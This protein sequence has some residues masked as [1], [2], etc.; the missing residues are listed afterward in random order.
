MEVMVQS[1]RETFQLELHT[2]EGYALSI[3]GM[4]PIGYSSKTVNA[5]KALEHL[6]LNTKDI[7]LIDFILSKAISDAAPPWTQVVGAS[8]KVP[9]VSESTGGIIG[10]PFSQATSSDDGM[11]AL[12][13]N[14]WLIAYAG[15]PGIAFESGRETADHVASELNRYKMTLSLNKERLYQILEPVDHFI[16]VFDGTGLGNEAIIITK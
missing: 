4:V 9:G 12:D 3:G 14:L 2:C 16:A 7:Y 10:N 6:A 5:F 11:E 8:I 13:E 15:G 1:K